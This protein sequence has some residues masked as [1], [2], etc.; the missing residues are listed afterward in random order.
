MAGMLTIS[1]GTTTMWVNDG[2]FPTTTDNAHWD[3]SWKNWQDRFDADQPCSIDVHVHTNIQREEVNDMRG[4]F[5]IFVIDPDE[6]KVVFY[7]G[8]EDAI[9][10]DDEQQAKLYAAGA[11]AKFP[12]DKGSLRK[13][14]YKV[15][16]ICDVPKPKEVQK[17]Q[18]V[19]DD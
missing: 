1:A 5:E 11:F 14:V 8:G 6:E 13:Y 4:L 16:K 19:K 18:I 15:R 12:F 2:Y 10:A 7:V 17:V 9:V 3:D